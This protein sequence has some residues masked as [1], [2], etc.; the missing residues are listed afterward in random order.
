MS[1]ELILAVPE[2]DV[3][4]IREDGGVRIMPGTW[5]LA[6]GPFKEISDGTYVLIEKV[7]VADGSP[8]SVHLS[9]PPSCVRDKDL[10]QN[11]R[12]MGWNLL[13]GELLDH[14]QP[15]PETEALTSREAELAEIQ[16][17]VAII[18]ADISAAQADMS[19]LASGISSV[20]ALLSAPDTPETGSAASVRAELALSAV[21]T[22]QNRAA[23]I[24]EV[25]ER[26]AAN[27]VAISKATSRAA[28]Y[29][30]ERSRA[31]LAAVQPALM[32]A[33]RLREHVDTMGLYVGTGVEATLLVDGASAPAADKL[34]L[35][36]RR[37]FLD[38]ELLMHLESG[39]ADFKDVGKL[40]DAMRTDPSLVERIFGAPRAVV[41]MA[42][43]RNAKEY[44]HPSN[45]DFMENY[46]AVTKNLENRKSFLLVR[47]GQRVWLVDLP[48]SLQNLTRL[49]PTPDD[50]EAPY[51]KR[52]WFNEPPE[53]I[54]P[55]SL[56]YAKATEQY[57]QLAILYERVLLLLWGLNDRLGLFGP[58]AE[59]GD[60][61]GFGDPTLQQER[62]RLI[63]DDQMLL[64]EG[65]PSYKKWLTAR[66]ANLRSGSRV[67]VLWRAAMTSVSAPMA[68]K[69]LPQGR[70]GYLTDTFQWK[71]T[72][73]YAVV[74]A[75]REGADFV[76][77]C[78]VSKEIFNRERHDWA[79]KTLNAK[80]NLSRIDKDDSF[81]FLVLDD[82][83]AVDVDHYL[84]ARSERQ[85]YLDYV[86]L[87]VA[88]RDA[89]RADVIAEA[90]ALAELVSAAEDGRLQP[91]SSGWVP[92]IREAIRD[93]RALARGAALPLPGDEAWPKVR[94][95]LLEKIWVIAGR[96]EDGLLA[97]K[98]EAL[99]LAGNRTPL[100][101]SRDGRNRLFLYASR[102]AEELT[103]LKE[104]IGTWPFVDRITV[105][106]HRG[107]PRLGAERET[108]AVPAEMAS[109]RVVRDFAPLPAATSIKG[110]ANPDALRAALDVV[111]RVADKRTVLATSGGEAAIRV[112]ERTSEIS[113]EIDRK[114]V[115]R[116][117]LA[118]V[119]GLIVSPVRDQDT[120]TATGEVEL[121]VV[122]YAEDAWNWVTRRGS[123]EALDTLR[124][125]LATIYKN[126]DE[127]IQGMQSPESVPNRKSFHCTLSPN[128]AG[129]M[130]ADGDVFFLP[131]GSHMP[132]TDD[133]RSGDGARELVMHDLEP[134]RGS[135][136]HKSAH[137]WIGPDAAAILADIP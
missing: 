131:R 103:P 4:A 98:V 135:L 52:G 76:V 14:F 65:K 84:G 13:V 87:L 107:E 42:A 62:F 32:V 16:G 128:V 18:H 24:T 109:E 11:Y 82:V 124:N 50:L 15:V 60:Y 38:E 54:G 37:L 49:F 125:I 34:S 44:L 72:Q 118:Q 106:L 127:V 94:E 27:A 35:L 75:R 108:M 9:V 86:A 20:P 91:P 58:F 17:R 61:K 136:F 79:Y 40:G 48:E 66:N 102:A 85:H 126:P 3:T 133:K 104:M 26:I 122:G 23:A 5:W 88:V 80:V 115:R 123:P 97:D 95:T 89:V 39:G 63:F 12:I 6:K 31:A 68:V 73:R 134:I 101:L 137:R 71:P 21:Q 55:E 81:S 43:R 30:D 117:Y 41:A 53:R 130:D 45:K 120:D 19:R 56:D 110:F 83:D 46:A 29:Y 121:V 99:C 36:Q 100:R 10:G 2:F 92:A 112:L 93:W 25:S 116:A 51:K 77:D 59:S 114:V 129:D 67:A 105:S 111:R 90:P 96:S 119:S 57:R 22:M 113:S 33:S 47:D 74:V 78:P 7:E 70:E 28:L 8:H 69:S 132:W 1:N 64:G